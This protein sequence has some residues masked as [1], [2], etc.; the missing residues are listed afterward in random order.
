MSP[1][2]VVHPQIDFGFWC[3]RLPV[4]RLLLPFLPSASSRV[5]QFGFLDIIRI[6]REL[7]KAEHL[8]GLF[9]IASGLPF[10]TELFP[11]CQR[12]FI[13]EEKDAFGF[14]VYVGLTQNFGVVMVAT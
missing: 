10:I 5:L 12:P 14:W 4:P 3:D 2:Q 6:F 13:T 8:C 9:E 7:V 11:I 1:R